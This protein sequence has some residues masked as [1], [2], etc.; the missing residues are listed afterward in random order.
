MPSRI[1]SAA[2]VACS[3][4][5]ARL[6]TE[7]CRYGETRTV[8]AASPKRP[9]GAASWTRGC[10]W[11]SPVEI[12]PVEGGVERID[13]RGRPGRRRGRRDRLGGR[14]KRGRGRLGGGGGGR[15]RP[16]GRPGRGRGRPGRGRGRP[17]RSRGRP[18]RSRMPR[19][20][21]DPVTSIT[22]SVFCSGANR[23]GPTAFF[24]LQSTRGSWGGL[25]PSQAGFFSR[26][27]G[28]EVVA[29]VLS[30]VGGADIPLSGRR[31]L[32]SHVIVRRK[33][34]RKRPFFMVP[35][36][37]FRTNTCPSWRLHV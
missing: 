10:A 22:G 29:G 14:P 2:L 37:L 30:D 9:S 24:L 12:D 5:I 27:L 11:R 18:G 25:T 21:A 16:R 26:T 8:V 36:G 13:P 15:G 34:A 31:T 1:R 19:S 7:R 23:S 32:G 28:H 3:N 4:S 33:R 6:Y 20:A 35:S 17:G